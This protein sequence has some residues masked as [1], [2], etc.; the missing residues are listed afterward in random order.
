MLGKLVALVKVK[1]TPS[2]LRWKC[3]EG[4]ESLNSMVRLQ[5][6]YGAISFPINIAMSP[7]GKAQGFDS[8]ISLVRPQ[9][10][11]PKVPRNDIQGWLTDY[12]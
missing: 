11:L 7:S 5:T 12:S 6:V 9:P 4:F 2:R 1:S 10:S 8:C 3:E